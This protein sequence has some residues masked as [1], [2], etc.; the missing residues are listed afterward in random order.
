MSVLMRPASIVLT[1]AALAASLGL[2]A[3][4]ASAATKPTWTITKGGAVKATAKT[5][6]IID[7]RQ[8]ESLSCG[9]SAVKG[10]LKSG[11]FLSG[12]NAGTATAATV[13]SCA[14]DG[15]SI[16]ITASHL[17]WHLNLVS[18]NAAKGVTTAT[19]T[20]IHMTLAVPAFGCTADLDGTG[21]A[22]DNGILAVTY[23]NK[24]GE[25]TTHT[26]GSRLRLFGVTAGCMGVVKSGDAIA[27]SSSFAL[28]PKQ[29]ITRS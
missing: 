10:K 23:S 1:C 27:I 11:S 8:K 19:L 13:A 21:K 12:T 24:T 18:Y 15:F 25:L 7:I 9:S 6:T 29:K 20:G 3:G 14:L 2:A 17:P 4:P 5:L 28:S 22:A 16:K 26:I